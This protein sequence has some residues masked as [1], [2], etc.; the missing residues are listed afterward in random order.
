MIH[1]DYMR[2]EVKIRL[3][4]D[5]AISRGLLFGLPFIISYIFLHSEI[6]ASNWEFFE[7]SIDKWIQANSRI[8]ACVFW[9]IGFG[10]TL[11]AS[12][13]I[14]DQF[15]TID[16]WICVGLTSL[17]GILITVVQISLLIFVF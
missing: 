14:P 7:I 4:N 16:R 8:L 6:Y 11:F 10:G 15:R 1:G 17:M 13:K 5:R 12:Y 9:F 2:H 3:I